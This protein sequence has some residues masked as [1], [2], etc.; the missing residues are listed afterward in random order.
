[1]IFPGGMGGKEVAARLREIDDSVILIVSS[2][3]SN[4]AVMSEFRK[5]G[6]DDVIQALVTRPSE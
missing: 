1:V 4:T 2:G 3:H 6:F 5:Y